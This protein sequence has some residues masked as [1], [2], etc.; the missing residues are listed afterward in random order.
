MT[1]LEKMIENLGFKEAWREVTKALSIGIE[2]AFQDS[3]TLMCIQPHID[4]TDVAAGGTIAKLVEEGKKIIYVTMTDGRLGTSDPELWPE[5]L[6]AIRRK[7]QEKAAEI[8]G[9]SELV[10][11]NYRDGEL[12]P[13]LKAREELIHLIRKY[14]PDMIITVDP[15]LT[16]EAHPDHIATGLLASQAALFASFPHVAPGDLRDNLK[17][18]QVKFIAYYWTRRPNTYIDITG[19]IEKKL[20]AVK[21]HESQ[22]KS[23]WLQFEQLLKAYS[24]LMGK[25]IDVKYAEAFKVLKPI[26]LHSNIFSEDI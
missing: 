24:R 16:Y 15:W 19:Y 12:T 22:F 11:L 7:E 9:V 8:L 4:D 21:A 5:K 14:R 3:Q 6:A 26:H 20:E 17:P 18:H 23:T 10:W 1:P 2:R 13:S 25:K